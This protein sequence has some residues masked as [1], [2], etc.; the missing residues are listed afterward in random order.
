M[1][2]FRVLAEQSDVLPYEPFDARRLEERQSYKEL[3]SG[4]RRRSFTCAEQLRC[5]A[6]KLRREAPEFN[7]ALT[8]VNSCEQ[9]NLHQ[10]VI[11]PA[12]R[13]VLASR[14]EDSSQDMPMT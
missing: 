6:S 8:P 7:F 13:S 5:D 4:V 9:E 2:P 14:H 3:W 11:E 1:N 12:F 10:G